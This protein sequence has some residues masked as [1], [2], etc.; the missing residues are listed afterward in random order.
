MDLLLKCWSS[1][2]QLTVAASAIFL[3]FSATCPSLTPS[4]VPFFQGNVGNCYSH[5]DEF[6]SMREVAHL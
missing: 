5:S 1:R 2:C 6:V 3:A 4:F